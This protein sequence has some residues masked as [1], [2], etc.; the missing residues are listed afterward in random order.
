L[1]ER[2]VTLRETEVEIKEFVARSYAQGTAE[3]QDKIKALELST[4][5]ADEQ[6][7]TVFVAIKNRRHYRIIL[8]NQ[9]C[10]REAK[11]ERSL[12]NRNPT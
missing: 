8:K 11:K 7:A 4:R 3:R 5:K 1:R 12:E 10:V 6:K 2:Q 9:I